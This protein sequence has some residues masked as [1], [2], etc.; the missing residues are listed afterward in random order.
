MKNQSEIFNKKLYKM[1]KKRFMQQSYNEINFLHHIAEENICDRLDGINRNF[2]NVLIYGSRG[3][4]IASHHKVKNTYL[5]D[6]IAYPHTNIIYD[7]E[8]LPF[9]DNSFDAIFS[10]LHLHHT[11][12]LIGALIQMQNALKPDGLFMAVVNGVY[13]LRELRE[14]LEQAEI[15]YDA[16]SPRIA[17]FMDIRDTGALM[18]RAGLKLPVI[19]DE[20][21]NL[22]YDNM[23]ALMQELRM[24]GEAN[25]LHEQ[26]KKFIT[27]KLL[28]I[29]AEIYQNKFADS[30]NRIIA[31]AHLLYLTGWKEHHSQQQALNRGSAKFSMKDY[32]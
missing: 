6:L 26:S 13:S 22:S 16:I 19:D 1:R 4:A 15:H 25:I 24:A 20:I 9:A 17:P 7:E 11:N 18:Q 28:N 32:L 5:A 3:E 30:E 2:E 23:F 14:C 21:I 27:P 31:T 8:L 29:A 10:I 12:D